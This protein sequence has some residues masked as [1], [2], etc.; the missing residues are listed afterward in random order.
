MK[1]IFIFAAAAVMMT[2]FTGCNQNTA[3]ESANHSVTGSSPTQS[4]EETAAPTHNNTALQTKNVSDISGAEK[5]KAHPEITENN[6]KSSQTDQEFTNLNI[7]ISRGTL[8]IRSGNSFSVTGRSGKEPDYEISDDTL[9]F[10]NNGCKE[11]EIILPADKS[12]GSLK[13]NISDGHIY[14]ESALT[15]EELNLSVNKG[16]ARLDNIALSNDSCVNA[17]EGS[18]SIYGS[19]E[20]TLSASCKNGHIN[21]QVPF[22]RTECSYDI[23]LSEG[24]IRLDS[25]N[26]HGRSL[27][28]NVDNNTERLLKL[29]SVRGDI[30]VEFG[31]SE[32][33]WENEKSDK[34]K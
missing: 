24:N 31:R 30:S 15:A 9:Y 14:A 32:A 25:D 16:D 8:Y 5:T 23:S 21:L 27:V 34:K 13:L 17:D 29:N 7:E 4:A 2:A 12:Y 28:E 20:Q 1:K 18:A 11:T 6:D 22:D 10:N 19:F 3:S 26:Y 33:N